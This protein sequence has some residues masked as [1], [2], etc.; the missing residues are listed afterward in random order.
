MK[1]HFLK[2]VL[3]GLAMVA[4]FGA[5]TML[6]WN[7]LVPGI[8]GLGA[9]NLWQAL[10]LLVL[11]RLLFGGWGAFGGMRRWERGHRHHDGN[12][13]REKWE[14]MTPEER[15]EFV[16]RLHRRPFGRH[17]FFGPRDFDTNEEADDKNPT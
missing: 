7:V 8:F 15:K 17:D 5:V 6:L 3:L 12:P 10:G 4:G 11:A 1:L 16:G 9:I 13:M 2:H 14:K